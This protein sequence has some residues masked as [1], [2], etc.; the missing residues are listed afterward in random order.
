[1]L[2]DSARHTGQTCALRLVIVIS[3]AIASMDLGAISGMDSTDA[4]QVVI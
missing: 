2:E 4:Q 3:A 1:M